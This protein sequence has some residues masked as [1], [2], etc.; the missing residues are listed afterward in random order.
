MKF[1][2]R[3]GF[4]KA[5]EALQKDGIDDAL[6]NSIWTVISMPDQDE[7]RKIVND[8]NRAA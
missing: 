6:K 3:K 4:T 2:D 8:L 5:R 1:S 7:V